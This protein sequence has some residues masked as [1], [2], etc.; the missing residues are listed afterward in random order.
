MVSNRQFIIIRQIVSHF[1]F[2]I[3]RKTLVS[4]GQ[5]VR[6]NNAFLVDLFSLP[7]RKMQA[8]KSTMQ[9]ILT[10]VRRRRV[11]LPINA[12]LSACNSVAERANYWS[13]VEL[14]GIVIQ[15]SL[16]KSQNNISHSAIFIWNYKSNEAGAKIGQIGSRSL[17]VL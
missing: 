9:S 3:T 12:E 5:G 13:K 16:A 1:N 17:G 14:F 6:E 15:R 4:I 2:D 10:I 11:L 7:I 8:L